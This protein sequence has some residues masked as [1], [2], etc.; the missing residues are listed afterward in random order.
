M[1]PVTFELWMFL[2]GLEMSNEGVRVMVFGLTNCVRK[3]Y[4]D[5]N[6]Y[7]SCYDYA[8]Q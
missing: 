5:E 4:I 7:T 2:F 3:S 6:F 8:L 1:I